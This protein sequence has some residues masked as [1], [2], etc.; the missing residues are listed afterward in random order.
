MSYF[1]N[2][3]K[4]EVL[5]RLENFKSDFKFSVR[6][7][8]QRKL[9][10]SILKSECNLIEKMVNFYNTY[11]PDEAE[12]VREN[13]IVDFTYFGKDTY[14]KL[15]EFDFELSLFLKNILSIAKLEGDPNFEHYAEYN[16]MD[17]S[18]RVAYFF[19]IS[20]G[21]KYRHKKFEHVVK[22]VKKSAK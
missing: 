5:R 2:T 4:A 19:N 17:D 20:I 21:D 14:K 9:V 8:N 18:S 1:N 7:E 15:D 12:F 3:M 16:S 22:K 13:G 11:D 10:I 6:I